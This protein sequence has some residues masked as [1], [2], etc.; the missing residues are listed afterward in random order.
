MRVAL[1]L[2]ITILVAIVGVSVLSQVAQTPEGRELLNLL[3]WLS[4]ILGFVYLILGARRG[5][6]LRMVFGFMLISSVVAKPVFPEPLGSGLQ[7]FAALGG[8][9]IRAPRR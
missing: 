7:L 5:Q 3:N 9:F 8:L 4:F 2:I 1:A 6:V